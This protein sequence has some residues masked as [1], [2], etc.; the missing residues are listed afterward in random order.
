[1]PKHQEEFQLQQPLEAVRL[2]CK[3]AISDLNWRVFQETE[4]HFWCKERQE[5]LS[6]SWRATF[7]LSLHEVSKDQTMV[8]VEAENFGFGP[9]QRGHL[10]GEVGK[11]RN[12]ITVALEASEKLTHSQANDLSTE[13]ERLADLRERGI[14]SEEEFNTAKSRLLSN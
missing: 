7:N 14:L 2:A 12:K 11:L 6:F 8:A 1:M 5:V 3:E 4:S 13:I 9:I 10:E